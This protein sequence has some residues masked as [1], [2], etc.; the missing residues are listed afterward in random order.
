MKEW[1]LL[2]YFMILFDYPEVCHLFP[3]FI[4]LLSVSSCLNM[5]YDCY[6]IKSLTSHII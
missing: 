5:I 2:F 1:V 4:N 3:E 6:L